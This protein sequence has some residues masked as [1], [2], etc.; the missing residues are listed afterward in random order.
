MTLNGLPEY[1][2]AADL[3]AYGMTSEDERRRCPGAVEYGPANSPYWHR[4]DLAP[5]LV[6]PERDGEV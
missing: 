2:T 6:G 5:L 4:N 3:E 1:L